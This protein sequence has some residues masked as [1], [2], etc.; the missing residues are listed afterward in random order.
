[1]GCNTDGDKWSRAFGVQRVKSSVAEYR[2]LGLKP[3]A[4]ILWRDEISVPRGG[5]KGLT[6]FGATKHTQMS[7]LLAEFFSNWM[8]NKSLLNCMDEL[9]E[10]ARE[11]G[12]KGMESWEIYG[13]QDLKRSDQ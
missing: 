13:C 3:R 9:E 8:T 7:N 2:A 12:F 10:G 11:F 4:M 1:M 5:L 6:L